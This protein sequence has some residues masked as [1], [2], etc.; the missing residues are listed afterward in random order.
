[1]AENVLSF[2]YFTPIMVRPSSNGGKLEKAAQSHVG[3]PMENGK[4][5]LVTS[6]HP[7]QRNHS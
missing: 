3:H 7:M 6:N 5:T 1:M 4:L 2:M